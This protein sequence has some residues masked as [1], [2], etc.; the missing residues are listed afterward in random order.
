MGININIATKFD[1]AGVRSAKRELGTLKRDL[2]GSV[3]SLGSNI[4]V[5]GA[6]IAGVT[7]FLAKTVTAASNFSAQF[8]GVNQ[9][10]GNGAKAVQEYAAQ[11]ATLSG[12]SETAALNA[13]K[14]FGG[15]ATSAGLS[16]QAAADFAIELVK[17]A[18]D[19]ASFADV[20]VDEALNAIQ[21]G[22]AG[23]TEPLRN[24]QILL[25]QTTLKNRAFDMGLTKTTDEALTPQQKVLATHVELMDQMGVKAGDFVN[26]SETFGNQVKSLTGE[27]ANMER[28]IGDELLPVLEELMPEIRDMA[29]EFGTTLL[30][31]V[32]AINWKS[33]L[34]DLTG[35]A[36]WFVNNAGRIAQIATAFVLLS[37][38]VNTLRVMLDLGKIS[39][40]TFTYVQ[41]QM[42]AG[43]TLATIA[44]GAL[45]AALIT[46]GVGAVIVGIG[47]I[48]NEFLFVKNETNGAT[49][50][51]NNYKEAT[52]GVRKDTK[53]E[54]DNHNGDV[55][56]LRAS[57]S[58]ATT[59]ALSY[60]D[61]VTGAIVTN[62]PGSPTT[63]DKRTPDPLK[64]GFS[65]QVL[66]NG[67]WMNAT[68]TGTKWNLE[69]MKYSAPSSSSSSS[70]SSSA[71]KSPLE[72][73]FEDPIR[74]EKAA[75]QSVK[76]QTSG[77]SKAV[78]EWI[79]SVD[80]PVVAAREAQKRIAKNGDKAI[81]NLTKK[82]EQSSA[83]QAAA[84]AAAA[85]S[86]T[87]SFT[88]AYDD[89]ADKEAAALAERQRV[90]ESFADS[91]KLTFA[92]IKNGIINAFD[93][94]EL[95][96]SSNA[97]TRN[98]DKLLTRLR[99]FATNVKSLASMGLNP[100]LLQQ[101]I[102]AGPMGGARLAE[103]LV[104]G[105]A[106]GLSALNAGYSEFGALSSQI[107]QTGT[108]SLFNQSGQQSIYNINVD[109]GVGS[110]STIGKAIVDAIKAYERTSGAVWQ[111]A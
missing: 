42:A 27:W 105:G 35:I 5:L 109:G 19:L 8:E 75:K 24:F 11:A 68:W 82:Y 45:R 2:S 43:A 4:A 12:I 86:I 92:G 10:F 18:G 69:E 49:D 59:V 41:S 84:A 33:L 23:Q 31:A 40:A 77:L 103:A 71:T 76:L 53:T 101:V 47:L 81:A 88:V 46:T 95:G 22:L 51:V 54:I 9:T 44:V 37:T 90:F 28:A 6:G 85:S 111:G 83:G 21:S 14:N 17:A 70:S 32:K 57:W 55:N 29:R 78:S 48:A 61:A 65:Y 60:R 99:S 20:P 107:A 66:Q 87:E 73:L 79:T 58:N 93:L 34:A 13:A 94:K 52:K 106:G 74:N 50:A 62:I 38:A 3:S 36:T 26:Y 100:A 108:E 1:S 80:K 15:F 30:N 25:D 96:G 89:T 104:M 97:I 64:P 72:Q 39:M 63:G 7:G 56:R 67:K 102:S 91:V 16:G 110:G 98:M